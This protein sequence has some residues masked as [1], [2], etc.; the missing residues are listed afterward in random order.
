[1]NGFE[2]PVTL[3]FTCQDCGV[4]A[5]NSSSL[6]NPTEVIED[7]LCGISTGK[8]CEDKLTTMK[9]SCAACGRLS[10]DAELL[11]DPTEEAVMNPY[12]RQIV[13]NDKEGMKFVCTMEGERN[14]KLDSNQSIPKLLEELSEHERRRC[15]RFFP[16]S[17]RNLSDFEE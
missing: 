11:C 7:N 6:C 15:I 2:G 16:E 14:D 13:V 12:E 4:T 3:A 8:V 17:Y 5:D 1:M 9:Y 10:A